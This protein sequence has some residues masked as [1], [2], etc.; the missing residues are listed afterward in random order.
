M[1]HGGST[2]ALPAVNIGSLVAP[3]TIED[4]TIT[5]AGT[6]LLGIGTNGIEVTI[7]HGC[8]GY[9]TIGESGHGNTITNVAG[10][11]IACSLFG[12]GTEKC[13]IAYN[14]IDANNT[15]GSP[16]INTGADSATANTNTPTLYLDIHNNNVQHTQGNGILST[17]RSTDGTGIFKIENNSVTNLTAPG[18][19][20]AIRVDSGN[21]TE[22]AGATVCLKIDGNTAVGTSNASHTIT[23]PGIG[24]RQNHASGPVATFRIDGLTPNP[25]N[26]AQMEAYVGN[27]GQNPGSANGTFG[28][29][30]V[31]SISG[32]A[33]FQASTCTIP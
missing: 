3:V 23:N 28:A 6:G 16:G 25:S 20:Y 15:A 13:S 9:F 8:T 21:G 22:S 11:G 7:G 32:G 17:I 27:A 24:L 5:G 4:N 30:G 26:D 14:T 2:A 10:D 33:T 18:N 29:T 31:A 19:Q 12:T 1:V